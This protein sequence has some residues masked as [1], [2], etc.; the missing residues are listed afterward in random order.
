MTLAASFTDGTGDLNNNMYDGAATVSL[1]GDFDRDGDQDL[2]IGTDN[3]NYGGDGYG[4]KVYY[5]K[6]GGSARLHRHA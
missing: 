2:I 5:F 1:A 6:N 4:G 3:Y